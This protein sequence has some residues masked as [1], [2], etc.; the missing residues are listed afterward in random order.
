M[1]DTLRLFDPALEDDYDEDPEFSD[2][3]EPALW[4]VHEQYDIRLDPTVDYKKTVGERMDSANLGVLQHTFGNWRIYVNWQTVWAQKIP[5]HHM[6]VEFGSRGLGGERRSSTVWSLVGIISPYLTMRACWNCARGNPIVNGQYDDN[7]YYKEI[8]R[9]RVDAALAEM[10]LTDP[11]VTEEEFADVTFGAD[12]IPT[13]IPA[14]L[15][16]HPCPACGEYDWFGDTGGVIARP[17]D[18]QRECAETL[19]LVTGQDELAVEMRKIHD[20]T[21]QRPTRFA[22]TTV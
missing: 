14:V 7:G 5:P 13:R 3:F 11:T 21:G 12:R 1:P 19:A 17:D 4:L 6:A 20:P 10:R 18:F 8:N 9:E 2:L 22:Q 15:P 16:H